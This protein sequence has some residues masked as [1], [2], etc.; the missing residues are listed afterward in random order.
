MKRMRDQAEVPE[1]IARLSKQM[2]VMVRRAGAPRKDG[3]CVVYWM[4]RAMRIVDNPALDIAIEAGNL[5][6]LPVVVYFQVIPNYP[7]ANLRHYH[8]LQQG[9]RGVAEDAAERRVGFVVRRS[10]DNSLEGFLDE[11]GGASLSG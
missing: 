4:Q 8:F 10:P 11:V 1:E 9:L 2:R 5:L 7:N 6:G 3:R